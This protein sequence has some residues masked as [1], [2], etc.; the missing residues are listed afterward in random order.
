M[1]GVHRAGKPLAS[2]K[3]EG[4]QDNTEQVALFMSTRSL[5]SEPRV[6]YN[7]GTE[8]QEEAQRQADQKFYKS[9]GGG[10]GLHR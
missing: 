5:D 4:D 3:Y 10:S 2:Y 1:S 8:G 6:G 9:K 7:S